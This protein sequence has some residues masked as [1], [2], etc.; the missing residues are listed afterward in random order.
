MAQ[1]D[2]IQHIVA[3]GRGN[4][5]DISTALADIHERLSIIETAGY[6]PAASVAEI[7][8]SATNV[9]ITPFNQTAALDAVTLTDAETV[10]P[11]FDAGRNF[12]LAFE[13]SRTIANPQNGRLGQTGII[14]LK[15]VTTNKTISWGTSWDF[16]GTPVAATSE[17]AW[18]VVFYNMV[19]AD[20]I[21]AVMISA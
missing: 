12:I 10:T 6:M 14:W 13:D 20:S 9:A 5:N 21:M 3:A 11:D 16:V 15:Q 17:G 4:F 1:S 7:R 2:I 18:S 19:A 8:S